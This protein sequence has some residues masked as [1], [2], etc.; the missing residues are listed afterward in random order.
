MT[1]P[2]LASG[3]DAT[4]LKHAGTVSFGAPS[5]PLG[6]PAL[7]KSWT[8]ASPKEK[9]WQDV[10]IHTE[11][12]LKGKAAVFTVKEMEKQG[13][14]IAAPLRA[15]TQAFQALV[16]P[17]AIGEEDKEG[18]MLEKPH[19]AAAGCTN[20][21]AMTNLLNNC[22]GS[23]MLGMGFCIAN[24]GL[25]GGLL[26]MLLSAFLNQRTMM[27][28]LASCKYAGCKPASTEIGSKAY[29]KVGQLTLVFM[30]VFMGFFC[31]V[32]YVD[33]TADSLSG[34]IDSLLPIGPVPKPQ[35]TKTTLAI[36]CWAAMLV[37]PT[38]LRSMSLVA[39]LSFFAFCGGVLIVISLSVVCIQILASGEGTKGDIRLW[40]ESAAGFMSAFPIIMLVFS[41]Q[42]GGDTVLETMKD[43]RPENQRKVLNTTFSLVFCLLYM[44]G[45]LCY[46]TWKDGTKGDVLENMPS[47]SVPAIIVQMA[48]L[49]LVVLSYMVM[50]IPCKVALL[51]LIFQKNEACDPKD[52]DYPS[53]TQFYG[54]T[55]VLNVL[56]LLM[57]LAVSDLSMVLGFDG[58]VCTNFVAFMLPTAIFMK[59]QS[60]PADPTLTAYKMLSGRNTVD[61]CIFLL[62]FAS[63]VLS[64]Y[65]LLQRFMETTATA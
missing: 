18:K 41:V 49:D 62:G 29:G 65:Q 43:R 6:K 51:D 61:I 14:A 9:Q 3:G 16:P 42:A 28:N 1:E 7:H 20:G 36:V 35:I 26:V 52:P 54:I 46:L 12:F 24:L 50:A 55:I 40:P 59:L 22:L 37:P 38:F 13:R 39:V 44:I 47:G 11:D 19:E 17:P 10:E 25:V 45:A 21:E 56:A 48:S 34:L 33:A 53:R 30:V 8:I 63:L 5:L 2:L 64:S 32:S 58:A 57:A 23:G 27:M 60:A 15:T 4:P 31:M